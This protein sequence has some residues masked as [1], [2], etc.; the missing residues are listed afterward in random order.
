MVAEIKEWVLVCRSKVERLIRLDHN[1]K[2]S[3]VAACFKKICPDCE[4][5]ESRLDH[6]AAL[7]QRSNASSPRSS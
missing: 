4:G 3:I 1:R 5:T 6:A 7:Q 2:I